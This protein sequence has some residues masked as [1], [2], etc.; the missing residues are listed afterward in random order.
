M[1]TVDKFS[2]IINFLKKSYFKDINITSN[3]QLDDIY[4][5]EYYEPLYSFFKDNLYRPIDAYPYSYKNKLLKDYLIK[6]RLVNR[7]IF[8]IIADYDNRLNGDYVFTGFENSNMEIM[9]A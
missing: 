3:N 1:T 9:N 8:N 4:T 2:E 7:N 6:P 5:T